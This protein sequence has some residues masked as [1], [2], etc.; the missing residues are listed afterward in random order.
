MSNRSKQ[1]RVGIY[2]RVSTTAKEGDADKQLSETLA[3]NR[4][5]RYVQK[6]QNPENQLRQMKEVCERA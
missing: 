4:R 1:I 6:G 5:R 3:T 2:L